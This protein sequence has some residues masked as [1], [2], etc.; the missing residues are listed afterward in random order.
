MLARGRH[1]L[2]AAAVLVAFVGAGCTTSSHHS[3][4]PPPSSPVSTTAAPASPSTAPSSPAPVLPAGCPAL[5]PLAA[6]EQALGTSLL[7]E[8][9][10][11]SAAPV[12]KSGR[13]GR[14]TCGYG[15]P[16]ATASAT[17][18]PQPSASASGSPLVEASYITYVDA[19]TAASRV[20]L[21]VQTDGATAGVN[22]VTVAGKPAFVLIGKTWNELVMADGARTIVVEAAPSVLPPAR[23][24]GALES[25]AAIMLRFGATTSGATT[26]GAPS[27]AAA[28]TP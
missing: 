9:T 22:K 27:S 25:M 6:V 7:G 16:P 14:V 4:P 15:T 18:K 17:A 5:L 28:S 23:A 8:V 20:A 19:K 13:T 1:R 11:L 2:A 10:Y 21:T 24:A 12:P 3:L 26:S